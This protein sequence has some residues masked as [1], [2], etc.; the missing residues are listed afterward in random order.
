MLCKGLY[1]RG[2]VCRYCVELVGLL[3]EVVCFLGVWQSI[4]L[5]CNLCTVLVMVDGLWISKE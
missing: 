3:F 1:L 2:V 4:C 5:R